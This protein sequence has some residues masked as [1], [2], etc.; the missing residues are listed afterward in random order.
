MRSSPVVLA[1]SLLS[2]AHIATAS[3]SGNWGVWKS[4][5]WTASNSG[6]CM[7][8]TDAQGVANN[9]QALI[10]T[11]SDALAEKTLTENFHDYTDSVIELIDNG[12]P[13]GPVPVSLLHYNTHSK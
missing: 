13:N 1:S 6:A 12:C 3:W 8:A 4:P 5:D 10:A 7:S 11:Y 9:F 2:V